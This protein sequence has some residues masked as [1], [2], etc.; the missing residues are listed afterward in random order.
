MLPVFFYAGKTTS[1]QESMTKCAKDFA[2][3]TVVLPAL[4]H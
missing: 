2:E 3:L 1:F 4:E